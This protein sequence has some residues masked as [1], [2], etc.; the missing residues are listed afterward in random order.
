MPF[1][2][3]AEEFDGFEGPGRFCGYAAIIEL[4]SGERIIPTQGGIHGGTFEWQGAFGKLEVVNIGWAA[5]PREEPMPARTGTGQTQ[6]PEVLGKDGHSKKIWDRANGVA[7]FTSDAPLTAAQ[8]E[9]IDR[10]GL[11]TEGERPEN[12]KYGTVF[13]WDF[14]EE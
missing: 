10:V 6:F 13:S 11:F 1:A 9:A 7:I 12:C 2:A 8:L 5:K 14:G 4:R 3:L